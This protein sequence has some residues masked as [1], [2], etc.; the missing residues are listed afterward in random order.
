MSFL[1]NDH[2]SRSNRFFYTQIYLIPSSFYAENLRLEIKKSSLFEGFIR[3]KHKLIKIDF[4]IFMMFSLMHVKQM[5]LIWRWWCVKFWWCL[6]LK[7]VK[8]SRKI[9]KK[10]WKTFTLVRVNCRSQN[11][12]QRTLKNK[13]FNE[14][15]HKN[16]NHNEC[17]IY[18][19]HTRKFSK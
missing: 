6:N 19:L 1:N 11:K 5:E 15:F 17:L 9:K 8:R 7:S 10:L 2:S 13:V 3:A 4:T 12:H 16:P 18:K 14:T